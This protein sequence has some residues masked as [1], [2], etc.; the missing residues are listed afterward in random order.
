METSTLATAAATSSTETS[1][2][3]SI[4]ASAKFPEPSLRDQPL[5]S[6]KNGKLNG[7][8]H[9][10]SNILGQV[11]GKI[12]EIYQGENHVQAAIAT[13]QLQSWNR[14]FC[15]KFVAEFSPTR[16]AWF[17]EEN[18][19]CV[20]IDPCHHCEV[21]SDYSLH[22]TCEVNRKGT[23]AFFPRTKMPKLGARVRL[24]VVPGGDGKIIFLW[25]KEETTSKMV[26]AAQPERVAPAT[27][28]P[29]QRELA[30]TPVSSVASPATARPVRKSSLKPKTEQQI[31]AH[32]SRSR[33]ERLS[34][35][36]PKTLDGITQ[37]EQML[38]SA[39]VPANLC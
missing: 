19:L 26:V 2:D 30:T 14:D 34:M 25:S 20:I 38:F 1:T 18:Q 9:D 10:N 7:I 31:I 36:R 6:V 35:P 33:E 22:R 29:V 23:G 37:G 21:E 17:N 39:L 16:N 11:H 13:I 5:C 12:T 24:F 32:Q 15:Q 28:K 3:T 8:I 27:P 4:T